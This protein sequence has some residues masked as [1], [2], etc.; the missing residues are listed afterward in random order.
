MACG[1]PQ[2]SIL[3]PVLFLIYINDLVKCCNNLNAHLYADDTVL[4]CSGYNIGDM[5]ETMQ[6]NLNSLS[7]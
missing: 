5:R 6:K 1:V 2:G 3:G 7:K 4:Y